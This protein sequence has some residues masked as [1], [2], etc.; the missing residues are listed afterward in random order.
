MNV[1]GTSL[2]LSLNNNV[3]QITKL[4]LEK[5][6]NISFVFIISTL[7]IVMTLLICNFLYM[8]FLFVGH[9]FNPDFFKIDSCLDNGGKW[10]YDNKICE[11]E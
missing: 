4:I 9:E 11:Y 2:L 5:M 10:N 1:I 7:L 6:K 3:I 8:C